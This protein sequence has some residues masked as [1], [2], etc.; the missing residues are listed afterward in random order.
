MPL[1]PAEFVRTLSE[2]QS[3]CHAIAE[4]AGV[5]TST[6]QLWFRGQARYHWPL[7]PSLYRH[8]S[9]VQPRFERELTR[10]FRLKAAAFV[11]GTLTPANIMFFMQHYG[12]PTRLLDWTENSYAA[13]YFA[14]EQ[15]KEVEDA[16]V[17]VLSPWRLNEIIMRSKTVPTSADPILSNHWL[18]SDAQ[19]EPEAMRPVAVRAAHNSP[20]IRAQR[21]VFTLHGQEHLPIEQLVD[22]SESSAIVARLLI[23]RSHCAAIKR[24]LYGVDVTRGRFFPE[25]EALSRDIAYRYSEEYWSVDAPRPAAI[26]TPQPAKQ[27]P[28]PAPPPLLPPPAGRDAAASVAINAQ[29]LRDLMTKSGAFRLPVLNTSESAQDRM[30]T[31]QTIDSYRE[32]VQKLVA[33]I[34]AANQVMLE[35][36]RQNNDI[37][38]RLRRPIEEARA[39][40]ES[41]VPASVRDQHDLFSDALVEILADGIHWAMGV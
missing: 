21:G 40:Y 34:K 31:A 11:K 38:D 23:P 20:R 35:L 16:S 29:A 14:V 22:E 7:L 19:H 5:H 1:I 2:Y 24:E 39:K 25:L 32:V 17:W 26:S 4:T 36:G 33:E 27:P 10:D 3:R 30:P 18:R 12:L 6:M 41:E 9:P 28:L 13:L 15:A 37:Y 8:E